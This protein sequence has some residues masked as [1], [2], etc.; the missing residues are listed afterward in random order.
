[1]NYSKVLIESGNGD[2]PLRGDK[3]IISYRMY[4]YETVGEDHKGRLYALQQ[5]DEI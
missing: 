5:I 3:V 4:R 2:K 1:M